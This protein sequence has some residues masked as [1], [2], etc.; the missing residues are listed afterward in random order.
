MKKASA[1]LSAFS[2]NSLAYLGLDPVAGLDEVGRG[3]LAGP[4]V[5]AAVILSPDIHLPGVR[6][7]KALSSK[8]REVFNLAI[9]EKAL[10]VSL[11]QVESAEIDRI[12]ILKASLKAMAQ[13]VDNLDL[14]P[15]ALLIDGNQ[16][17]PHTLPQKILVK[18]DQRS[19]SVAAASIVAKVFRDNLMEDMHRHYP[20]YNFARRKGVLCRFV[21]RDFTGIVQ[22]LE[23][24][25]GFAYDWEVLHHVFPERCEQYV[26]NIHRMLRPGGK[27]LENIRTVEIAGKRGTQQFLI[28]PHD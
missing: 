18:G 26:A 9:R 2:P 22:D 7:S 12:N 5:A 14:R 23:C 8:Q 21:A 19:L 27:Y 3:C 1:S 4:V 13:A 25:F 16:P 17:I 11:A 10:A 20:H 6:D 24:S 15:R 28:L